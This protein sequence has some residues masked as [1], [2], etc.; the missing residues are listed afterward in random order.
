MNDIYQQLGAQLSQRGQQGQ[1]N[2]YAGLMQQRQFQ[3]PQMNFGGGSQGNPY[4]GLM[5]NLGQQAQMPSGGGQYGSFSMPTSYGGG[6]R[7]MGGGMTAP[8][9]YG[10]TPPRPQSSSIP[11]YTMPAADQRNPYASTTPQAMDGTGWK[12]GMSP[13][14]FQVA[15]P[16]YGQTGY[17]GNLQQVQAQMAGKAQSSGIPQGVLGASTYT[18]NPAGQ[19]PWTPDLTP[20]QKVDQDLAS[21]NATRFG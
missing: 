7:P 9:Q 19:T 3:M 16:Y 13:Q 14:A 4:A 2:P 5:R 8:Q 21:W 11:G 6:Q 15:N 12:D 17:Y 20:Q 18:Q 1:G 10:A